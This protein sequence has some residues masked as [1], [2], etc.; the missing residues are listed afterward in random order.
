MS[1]Q[2]SNSAPAKN[3]DDSPLLLRVPKWIPSL[4]YTFV[5][6]AAVVLLV[7]HTLSIGSVEVDTTTIGLLALV[8]LIPIAPHIRRL[9]AGGVTAEIGVSE[10]RKLQA[11]AAELPSRDDSQSSGEAS[12]IRQRIDRDPPMG[13]AQLRIELEK[14][15]RRL[16]SAHLT[17]PR[18]PNLS[19]GVMAR[20]LQ[21]HGVLPVEVA[22][23]LANVVALANRA[24]HGEYVPSEVASEIGQVGLRVLSALSQ[25]E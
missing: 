10:A 17:E 15:L 24:V 14:E 3:E 6:G 25:L 23:P 22:D 13:L 19:L 9:S 2:M 11:E 7:L 20:D 21:E 8:L 12:S 4:A 5:F 1:D 18:P 16:Y